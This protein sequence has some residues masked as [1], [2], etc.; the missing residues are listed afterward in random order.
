[1]STLMPSVLFVISLVV[2]AL[3]ISKSKAVEVYVQ[4]I[5]QRL[6]P[7]RFLPSHQC[8][9]HCLRL[10]ICSVIVITPSPPACYSSPGILSIP[11]DFPFFSD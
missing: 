6:V 10:R 7:P 9:R 11:G 2:S 4:A 1:M 5:H 8:H 3:L